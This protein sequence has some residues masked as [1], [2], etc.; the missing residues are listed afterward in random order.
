MHAEQKA[1]LSELEVA[2][3]Q[4]RVAQQEEGL[5][6]G[7]SAHFG[8]YIFAFGHRFWLFSFCLLTR[9]SVPRAG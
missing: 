4:E 7:E 5:T 6:I 1:L 2:R 9:P 8:K 3:L